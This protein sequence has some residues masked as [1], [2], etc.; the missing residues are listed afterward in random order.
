LTRDVNGDGDFYDE[1]ETIVWAQGNGL[2]TFVERARAMEYIL[3][4]PGDVNGDSIV[5][6]EDL[7]ALLS[8]YGLCEGEEGY[9][10]AADFDND[11]CITLADLA[12][13]LPRYGQSCP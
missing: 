4:A 12:R 5:D 1:G 8:S 11:N 9:N 7:A 13:L 6:L 2:G 3:A 10:A